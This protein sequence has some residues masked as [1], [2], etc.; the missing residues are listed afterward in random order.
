MALRHTGHGW[1][2]EEAGHVPPLARLTDEVDADVV[3]LAHLP[4]LGSLDGERE[5]LGID[6]G[7]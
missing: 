4:V 6:V 5:R 7:R 3:I 1:W 2:H